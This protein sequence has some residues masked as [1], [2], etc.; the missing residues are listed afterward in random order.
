MT[1]ADLLASRALHYGHG[2]FTTLV[3]RDGVVLLWEYHWQRLQLGC[4]RLKLVCPDIDQVQ[5]EIQNCIDAQA[6]PTGIIKVMLLA[7]A[8]ATGYVFVEHLAVCLVLLPRQLPLQQIKQKREQGC[9]LRI[10]QQRL[11]VQPQLAGIKHL[12]RLEQVLAAS[13]VL[14]MGCDDGLMLTESSH[15]I[16]TTCANI[17]LRL[18]QQWVT[19]NLIQ[20]GVAGVARALVIDWFSRNQQS[21]DV[22]SVS[23][24][25]IAQAEEI[26]I[27]N[28]VRGIWP[29]V[30]VQQQSFAIGELTRQLQN[31][32]HPFFG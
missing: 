19:P 23:W 26:L 28:A 20:A 13:E 10:C 32:L 7:E 11:A 8:P 4:Q 2:C 22:R 1:P 30:R 5:L 6:E 25:D 14:E 21:V 16:E 17:F 9:E 15:V 12:N 18:A 27:C 31:Q 24:G 3:Y 29:V